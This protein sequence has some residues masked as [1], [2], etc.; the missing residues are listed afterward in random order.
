IKTNA[1][2]T[3]V[4][5][6][7]TQTNKIPQL[8]NM[9]QSGMNRSSLNPGLNSTI[10][11]PNLITSSSTMTNKPSVII[12]NNNFVTTNKPNQT[13][14]IIHNNNSVSTSMTHGSAN[15]S[16]FNIP[17]IKSVNLSDI[18]RQVSSTVNSIQIQDAKKLN[19]TD[20]LDG[21]NDQI[22][23]NQTHLISN[24]IKNSPTQNLLSPG[25]QSQWH[26][27]CIT[28]EL[29]CLVT[30]YFVNNTSQFLMDQFEKNN[31][32]MGENNLMK[33]R[34]EAN[35]AYKFRV[36]GINS[37][38][39]GPWSEQAAFF[40]CQPGFPGAPSN[41]K[42]TKMGQAAQIFW[43]PP[44]DQELGSNITEYSVYLQTKAKSNNAS[45][46]NTNHD[47][48]FTQIYCGSEPSCVVSAEVLTRAYVDLSAKPAILFRIAAKNEKGYGPATQVRWLQQDY[49][50]NEAASSGHKRSSSQSGGSIRKKKD[51]SS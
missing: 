31:F 37:C 33:R 28:K 39:R 11:K 18:S 7:S 43:E 21:T 13:F 14:Q 35:T 46:S 6:V 42:I 50:S 32:S 1:N 22:S 8:I 29:T 27:V 17:T 10:I 34:L 23:D 19:P 24:I 15:F 25:E 20:Q 36:A 3:V 26:D 45:P 38:G 47:L 9:S 41:I 48:C 5:L 40:T 44:E 2:P 4:K 16:N 12:K 51:S 30:D 49:G